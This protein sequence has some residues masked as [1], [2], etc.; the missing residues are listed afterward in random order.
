LIERENTRK[1]KQKYTKVTTYMI[2]WEGDG[3]R[4]IGQQTPILNA[5]K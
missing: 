3:K 5:G 2:I 4:S 1:E